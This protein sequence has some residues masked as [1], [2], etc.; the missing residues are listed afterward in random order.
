M[1]IGP[2]RQAAWIDFHYGADHDQFPAGPLRGQSLEEREV[3]ALVYDAEISQA[4]VREH[5]LVR[6]LGE[7]HRLR[8]MVRVHAARKA[9]DVGMFVLLRP[10]EARSAGKNDVRSLE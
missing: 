9:M 3:H 6:S 5:R 10:V 4:R 2:L 7:L 1:N 8:E